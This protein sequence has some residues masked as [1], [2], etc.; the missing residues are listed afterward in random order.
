[1][2]NH[3]YEPHP[4]REIVLADPNERPIK[5]NQI[6]RHVDGPT[7][8]IDDIDK[9]PRD[10]TFYESHGVLARTVT[11]TQLEQGEVF[12][13]GTVWKKPDVVFVGGVKVNGELVQNFTL[14]QDVDDSAAD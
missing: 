1:M 14:E 2:S 10:T 13:P 3:E 12:P 4:Q 8:R 6:W 9:E 5:K 11:Y 7:Y